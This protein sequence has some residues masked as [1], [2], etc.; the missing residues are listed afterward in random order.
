MAEEKEQS[1]GKSAVSSLGQQALEMGAR[2]LV[3]QA[4][5]KA[6]AAIGSALGPIGTVVGGGIGWLVSNKYVIGLIGGVAFFFLIFIPVIIFVI[7]GLGGGSGMVSAEEEEVLSVTK[8]AN[9]SQIKKNAPPTEVTYKITAKNVSA[10][11]TLKDVKISD[12]FL[13]L[14]KLIGDLG[15]GD[16]HTETVKHTITDT[17]EDKIVTNTVTVTGTIQS[18]GD[19]GLP[20]SNLDYYI[21]FRDT[22]VKVINEDQMKSQVANNPNWPSNFVYTDCEPGKT[23]WDYVEEKTLAAGVNSAFV[24]AVWI[25]ES[26]ASNFPGHLSCPNGG[27]GLSHTIEDLRYSVNCFLSGEKPT[28]IFKGASN[29]TSDQFA[30]LLDDFCDPST[31]EICQEPPNPPKTFL[32]SL[33]SWYANLV[34][35]GNYGA[36]TPSS[37]PGTPGGT[38]ETVSDTATAR[39]IIG[40][41]PLLDPSGWSVSGGITQTPYCSPCGAGHCPSHCGLP[42]WDIARPDIAWAPI[43]STHGGTAYWGEDVGGYGIYVVVEGDTYSTLYSHMPQTGGVN[44][45]C[46]PKTG[47]GAVGQGALIGWVDSTGWSGGHHLHYEIR[48]TGQGSFFNFP[49]PS[50]EELQAIGYEENPGSVTSDYK[51]V[52]CGTTSSP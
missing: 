7:F 52:G 28:D 50:L 40:N 38:G 20:G 13:G 46:V 43:Y 19:G 17:S 15:P 11:I 29:Y 4:L 45:A 26:G 33:K 1:R 27:I 5:S 30:R 37:T 34:P 49:R 47:S 21:P 36:L 12:G 8:T 18:Q 35:A 25:A 9:P 32:A 2:R 44:H 10:D 42:A 31:P 16:T 22:A 14:D 39:V 24:L 23:C 3:G 41:P 48:W 6:G 51:G